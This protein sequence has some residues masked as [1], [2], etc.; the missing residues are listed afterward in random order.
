MAK[1]ER[2]PICNVAVKPENLIRHLDATHPRHPDMPGLKAKLKQEPGRVVRPARAPLRVSRRYAIV[3]ALAVFAVG[4][5]IFGA[6]VLFPSQGSPFSVDGC[7]SD[8]DT[9]YHI[10]PFLK[11][12][13]NG[14][15]SKVPDELGITQ[16]CMHP[17]HVHTA[18]GDPAHPD[19]AKIHVESPVVQTY[20][21]GEFFHVWGQPFSSAQI[22]SYSADSTNH[23]SMTVDGVAS[24]AYGNLPL[25]DGQT[26]VITY[27]P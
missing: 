3:A 8:A 14:I 13:I 1:Q 12:L 4:F 21:L 6:P 20:T 2:C 5:A 10:H 11:I 26:I 7:I 18:Y 25:A 17:I 15:S 22:L 19:Y 23:I 16:A 9:I 24:T 27:G